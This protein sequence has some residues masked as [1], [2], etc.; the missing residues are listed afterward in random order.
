MSGPGLPE[1]TSQGSPQV[2]SSSRGDIGQDAHGT[3]H[4]EEQSPQKQQMRRRPKHTSTMRDSIPRSDTPSRE[5]P[6]AHMRVHFEDFANELRLHR[7]HEHR[8]R[9]LSRRRYHL[10]N[11]VALSSRLYRVGGWVH[12]GAVAISCQSDANGFARVH[13]HLQDLSDSC[14]SQW[15]HEINVLEGTHTA[16]SSV[17]ASFLAKLPVSSQQDCIDLIQTLRSNP[18]F[19]IE[20][21]KA[22]SPAQISSLSTSPKYQ[23]L[24][25]SVLTSL[26]QNRGRGSQKRR[27]KAYSKELEDYATSF[28]RSNPMSFLIH[29]VYGSCGGIQSDESRLRL[30]TWSTICATL[31]TEFEQAFH[32]ILTQVLRAFADMYEWQI[33]ERLELFL[34]SVLQKGG[35]LLEMVDNPVP[36]LHSE[37][38]FLDPFGTQEAQDFLDTAV[39][40]LFQILG[41]DG[42]IPSAPLALGRAI[43]GKLPTVELQ[44]QFRG[45]FF[46]QWYLR[47]FL[48]HA[49]EFPEV[50]SFVLHICESTNL[51]RRRNCSINST[52]VIRQGHICYISYGIVLPPAQTTLSVQCKISVPVTGYCRLTALQSLRTT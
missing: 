19:L 29:N 10:Q 11:A 14:I 33:K 12:T 22:M 8:K 50:G 25:E 40:E 17:Q 32:A 23:K 6:F 42:G 36:S 52:S 20:R 18:R 34:M 47:D 7:H 2:R 37:L 31:M 35:F 51:A 3:G 43:I 4:N 27:V 15:N 16:S 9:L 39:K 49:I 38:A 24:S 28:E 48:R 21:L 1:I 41:C 5:V 44:S 26:S 13:Q 46:F 30:F 45:T